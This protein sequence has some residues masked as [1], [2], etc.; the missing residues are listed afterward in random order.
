MFSM[1]QLN[2]VRKGEKA[3]N[4]LGLV[5]ILL[6]AVSLVVAGCGGGAPASPTAAASPAASP[7]ATGSPAASPPAATPAGTPLP[8]GTGAASELMALLGGVSA[9]ETVQYD[10]IVT[11]GGQ[12][13]TTHIWLKAPNK[14]RSDITAEGQALTTIGDLEAKAMYTCMSF[15]KVCYKTTIPEGSEQPTEAIEA[16]EQYQPQVIG[17]DTIDGK[18]CL[19]IEYSTQGLNNKAW[20][21]KLHGFP[22]IR[23]ETTGG[24]MGLAVMQSK[25]I[26]YGPISD[27]VFQPPYAVQEMP[28]LP[29][30]GAGG[31]PPLPDAGGNLPAP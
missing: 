22:V 14:W 26:D 4:K 5:L 30:A 12:T 16:I 29:P 2:R 31:M 27:S 11:S 25:N 9:I 15:D 10:M 7:T 28:G 21:W 13:S 8:A 20:I 3:M 6:V 24:P 17:T 18:E 19:V 1:A 23:L